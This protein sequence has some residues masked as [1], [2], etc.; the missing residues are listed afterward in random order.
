MAL[1]PEKIRFFSC[2]IRQTEIKAFCFQENKS[3]GNPP[4]AKGRPFSQKIG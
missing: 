2:F 3:S 4:S 1:L